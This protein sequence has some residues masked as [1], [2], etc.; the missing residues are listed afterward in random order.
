MHLY[1][2]YL[3][4]A[5]LPK[6]CCL[7]RWSDAVHFQS[8]RELSESVWISALFYGGRDSALRTQPCC[9]AYR[10]QGCQACSTVGS[11]LCIR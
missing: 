8:E 5:K 10:R 1:R 6:A 9:K 11:R 3:F 2:R 4:L 7:S